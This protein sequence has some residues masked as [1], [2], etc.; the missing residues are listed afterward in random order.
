VAR[1]ALKML[2]HL[3][4]SY[5][6]G[7]FDNRK[8][9]AL[10]SLKRPRTAQHPRWLGPVS[11]RNI[12]KA[13]AVEVHHTFTVRGREA[14]AVKRDTL[15][16]ASRITRGLLPPWDRARQTGADAAA[17]VMKGSRYGSTFFVRR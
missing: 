4:A 1:T 11:E 14:A 6:G 7:G 16:T 12:H 3:E 5:A 13:L 2:Q 8:K 9:A 15:I 17:L 10:A